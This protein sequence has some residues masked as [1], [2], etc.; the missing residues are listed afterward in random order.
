MSAFSQDTYRVMGNPVAHSKSPQIHAAFALET[1]QK[2]DYQRQLVPLDGFSAAVEAFQASGGKGLNITVPFKQEAWQLAEQRSARAE[3][4]GAVNTLWFDAAGRRVGDN[5]DGIGLVRDLSQNQRQNLRGKRL[6]V[7]GAG[8]AVRGVLQPLLAERP[9]TLVIANRT[10]SKAE[11]LVELFQAP[12]LSAAAY[13]DL[14]GYTFDLII[15]G[16]SA[17]LQGDLP[18]LPDGILHPGGCAY[19]MM[20]AAE[21]TTFMRWAQRQGA[22]QVADGLGMLVEQAAEAF[23]LWRGVRPQTAP[24]IAQLRG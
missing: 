22:G 9:A 12:C 19:D 11:T 16:T 21:P 23:W 1:G 17:S 6:L 3:L 13:A 8:G 20:Y 7:L 5:T 15:N 18:P 4:A 14:A 2:L 10:P 24:V